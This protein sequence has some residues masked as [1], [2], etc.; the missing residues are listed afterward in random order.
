MPYT[1]YPGEVPVLC[2]GR[3]IRGWQSDDGKLYHADLADVKA[4]R[5]H[6]RQVFVDGRRQIRAR[7]PNV[8]PT[9]PQGISVRRHGRVRRG[10]GLHHNRGDWMECKVAVPVG[11][12]HA[13]WL[14][15]GSHNEPFGLDGMSERTT[16]AVDGGEPIPLT[17]L[18]DTGGWAIHKW[19]RGASI[20]LEAGAHVLK[21]QNVRGGGIDIDAFALSDDPQWTPGERPLDPPSPG[22]HRVVIQAEEF[23]A[24]Q[25]SQLQ[26]TPSGGSAG[27]KT[28]I[29]CKPQTAQSAW[30][31]PGAEI[32]IFQSG[33]CR[34]FKEIVDVASVDPDGSGIH[35]SGKE[36]LV[37]LRSGDRFFVENVFS[38]LDAPGEWFSDR[39][40][41]RLYYGLEKRVPERSQVIAPVV[42]RVFA[43]VG[44]AAKKKSVSHVRISGFEIR[45]TDY[46]PD[47]G[48]EGYGMGREGTIHL[49]AASDCRIDDNRFVN[50]GKYAVAAIAGQRNRVAG[51]RISQSAEGGVLLVDSAHNAVASCWSTR[52]TTVFWITTSTTSAWSTNTSA[53]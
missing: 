32:H 41:G 9:D 17:N 23:S 7:A 28:F 43:L 38:E 30:A 31:A 5:W 50:V 20:P 13:F 21:W 18:P 27:S 29:Q 24:S 46:S 2:G 44:D 47:D 22:A 12:T 11:G 8:D 40:L 10:R 35:V 26:V 42:G 37:P 1:A 19:G 16:L 45:D 53:A 49:N 25:G 36:C 52:P 48:C 14:R 39:E 3:P 15:H 33:S 4:G 6:F 51:N 34:A